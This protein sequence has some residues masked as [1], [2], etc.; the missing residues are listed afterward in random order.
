MNRIS[1]VEKSATIR[2]D[3]EPVVIVPLR[4]WRQIEDL[5]EDQEAL[6]SPKF[7]RKIARGRK[8]A[9]SG[10]LVYPFR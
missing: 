3:K 5:L 9:A 6:A 4:L 7:L 1:I 10:K 2:V 8:D